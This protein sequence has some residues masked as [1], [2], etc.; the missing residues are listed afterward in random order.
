MSGKKVAV[1]LSGCGYLDGAEINES[2]LALLRLD[3][4]NAQVKIFAPNQ[5]QHHVINHLSGEVLSEKRNVMVEAARI[6]RGDIYEIK[7]C[8]SE[9]FDALVLPGGFGVAKNFSQFAFQGFDTAVQESFSTVIHDFYR[10]KKPIAALCIS[11]AI[12]AILLEKITL[13][14]GQ[15]AA[16]ADKLQELGHHHQLA[17]ANAVVLDE[18]NKIVSTPAYM[19]D[20]ASLSI[21]YEGISQCIDKTLDLCS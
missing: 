16:L 6:A 18:Q 10:Q 7:E 20:Q 2:V 19:E 9:D 1:L 14:L 21:I 3:Q 11:P 8:S 12:L 5:E 15:D 17:R 4:Q 13:T